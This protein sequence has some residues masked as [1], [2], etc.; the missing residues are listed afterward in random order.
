MNDTTQQ[1]D[2]EIAANVHIRNLIYWAT[3]IALKPKPKEADRGN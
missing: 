1:A 3:K 2:E